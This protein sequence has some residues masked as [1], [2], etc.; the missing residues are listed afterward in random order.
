MPRTVVKYTANPNSG[1][2]WLKRRRSYRRA[3]TRTAA[4]A[5]A[6]YNYSPSAS[7]PSKLVGGSGLYS[8]ALG[9][10]SIPQRQ[11]CELT[12]AQSSYLTSAP[13]VI[14]TQLFRANSIYDPDRT[15]V[16]GQPMGRDE[17]MALYNKYCVVS[18]K[19]T[20][21]FW[22][23]AI[24]EQYQS[25]VGILTT[26]E[27][28]V[29]NTDPRAM[30][31]SK[32]GLWTMMNMRADSG[33]AVALTHYFSAKKFFGLKDIADNTDD[34][35]GSAATNASRP[36]DFVVWVGPTGNIQTSEVYYLAEITYRVLF[37]DRKE[38]GQS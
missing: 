12:Y 27:A 37:Y 30:I 1:W 38:L 4:I 23:Q 33:S 29:T 28:G 32:R 3:A 31:E 36:A 17:M 16:G 8:R 15:G 9:L 7:A 5:R 18:A 35:G 11:M 34:I 19:I 25:L 24:N 26:S 10:Y 2:G 20:V 22:S 13:N 14:A 6:R 21:R